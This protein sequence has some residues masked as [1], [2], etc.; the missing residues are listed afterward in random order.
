MQALTLNGDSY[1]W[2]MPAEKID[3]YWS[4]IV[5][6]LNMVDDPDWT[7]DQVFTAIASKQAQVWGVVT[8][9]NINGIW[10]T[11][12]MENSHKFGVVWIAAGIPTDKID[13]SGG[14]DLFL[15]STEPWFKEMGCEYVKIVGRKGWKKALPEFKE[16]SV[17]LRKYL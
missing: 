12:I 13:L 11:K 16:H 3:L 14:I 2:T 10:V 8:D 5:N 9:G 6:F 17:E 7:N 4:Q 1:I 15:S